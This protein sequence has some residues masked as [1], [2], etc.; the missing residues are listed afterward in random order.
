MTRVRQIY[1]ETIE[2]CAGRFSRAIQAKEFQLDDYLPQSNIYQEHLYPH[3]K[4]VITA[5]HGYLFGEAFEG[6]MLMDH[7]GGKTAELHRRIWIGKGGANEKGF[8]RIPASQINLGGDLE[9][10]F[11]WSLGGFKTKGGADAYCHGGASLQELVIPVIS[12]KP[13]KTPRSWI[14]SS[15][16]HFGGKLRTA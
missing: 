13:K 14:E 8:I 11:P 12:L 10:A 1:T 15:Q 5:D 7:P 6:G 9:L 16:F 4:F 3:L 2:G